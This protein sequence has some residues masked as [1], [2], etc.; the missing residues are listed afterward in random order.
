MSGY[1]LHLVFIRER[2]A[3]KTPA[4]ALVR[5]AVS[6]EWREARRQATNDEL[7][8]QLRERYTVVVERPRLLNPDTKLA[9]VAQP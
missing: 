3:P 4:L 5:D 6:R 2:T 7:Y 9:E 1:G 8:Q